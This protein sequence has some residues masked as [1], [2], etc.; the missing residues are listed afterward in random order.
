[1]F[2]AFKE[3]QDSILIILHFLRDLKIITKVYLSKLIIIE[4]IL[5]LFLLVKLFIFAPV[6]RVL[7]E[8]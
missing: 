6:P 8:N 3:R 4:E 1:M 5:E 2:L 7:A